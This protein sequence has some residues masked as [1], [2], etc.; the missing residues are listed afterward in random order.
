MQS[1]TDRLVDILRDSPHFD[2][3]LKVCGPVD[4][5]LVGG[6]LR[7]ALT[8]RPVTDLDLIFPQDPTTLAQK[9]ACQIEG[10]WFWLDGQRR[11]SR[12]VVKDKELDFGFDFAPFRA[13]TLEQDLF[14]RDFTINA[15]ALPLT[16]NLSFARLHDPCHGVDDLQNNL[17]RRVGPDTFIDDPLRIVKG[18]RHATALCLEIEAETLLSMRAD[19]AGL[20]RVAPERTRQEVWKLLTDPKAAHG[21][22]LLFQSGAGAQL[23]GTGFIAAWP[24]L[25]DNLNRCCQQWRQLTDVHS[26]VSRWLARDVEQ[27][28]NI[29]TLLLFTLL[30]KEIDPCLPVL[31]ADQWKLSRKARATIAAVVAMD[32]SILKEF[33]AVARSARAYTWWA[34]RY[35]TN[36]QLLLLA[37]SVHP[38]A[39]EYASAIQAAIPILAHLDEQCPPDLVDGHWLRS[40]LSLMDGPEMSRAMQLLRN[41]EIAGE[42][43]N[44]AD[45]RRFLLSHYQNRD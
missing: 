19:V 27:G 39:V 5:Y 25:V 31:L 41:A 45:A 28:L 21:L 32:A 18:V 13:P 7:D 23:F 9:F 11:Q 33:S 14:D 29:Q 3:L 35:H 30:M 42:V 2:C 10:H 37:L 6:A 1:A 16:D 40:E 24:Q 36:P 15:L 44:E 22:Q 43:A 38:G 26:V 17:L 4:A 20:T 8:G 34:K 12:V